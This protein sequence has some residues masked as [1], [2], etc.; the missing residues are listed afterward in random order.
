VA[1]DASGNVYV[2]D[3]VNSA[4][5]E[6]PAGCTSAAYASSACTITTLGNGFSYPGSVAVDGSGNVYVADSGNNAVKEMTAG[7]ASSSCVTTLGGG[8]ST[9]AGVAV[10]GSGNV[11]V[12]DYGTPAV[13]E[14]PPGCT[15]AAYASSA[16]TI[17]TLGGGFSSPAGV[18]VDGSGNVYV[19]GY[20]DNAVKEMPSGCASSS[21]VTPLGGGFNRPLDVAVDGSGNVY[22]ADVYN[23]AVKEIMPHGVNFG[24]VAVGGTSAPLTLYFAFNAADSGITAS[25]LTQGAKGLD[26]ADAGGGSCDTNGT[27]F[28][29]SIGDSCTVNVTFT[30]KY[31]GARDGAVELSDSSGVIATGYVYGIGTGPQIVFEPA[32]IT[33]LGGGFSPIGMAVDASGNVY[34]ADYSNSAVKEM[35]S[36]C[37]SFSCVTTLGGGFDLPR[38]VAVDGSGNVYVADTSNNRVIEMPSGCASFSCVTTLGGGFDLPYGVAVDGSGNVYVADAD[39]DAVKE[40]PPGCT[41]AAYASSACAITALGGGFSTPV[42]VAVDGS[43]N[44]YVADYANNAVKEMPAGCASFSCV[45]TPGGGFST[46]TGVAVDASGNVYVA[47]EG[48]SAVKEM[49]AGCASFSCVTALGGGFRYPQGAAVDGSG[50]VYVADYGNNAVKELNAATP[51]SFNFT[52]ATA[53]D[54]TDTA[55]GT[56]IAQVFNIGN[57]PLVFSG[58]T[59]PADF[60]EASDTNPCTS[61]TSLSAG[62]ECDVPVE[63]TPVNVGSPLSEDVTLTDNSLN[64]TSVQQS[65]PLSGTGLLAATMSSPTPSSTLTAASTQFTWNAGPAGTTGYG[66]NVGTSPGGADLVNIYPL[67]GTSTTVTLPTN[68]TTI[69]V[70]LWTVLNGTTFLYHDYTYTEFTQSG[71]AITSPS[72]GS[73]LTSASTTFTWNAGPAGT[74]GYGLNVGTTGVGSADLVNIGPLSGTSVT[75]NLPTNGTLIYVRLWTILNGTTYLSND[76]T[77]TEFTQLASAITSPTPGGTLTSAS[78]TFTWNA[79]PAGTTGYGLNVGTSGVGS[80]DL[81]NIGPLSGTSVTVNLPTN[82][83]LIYVRLWTILNG[84]TYLSNDYTYTEFTQLASAI[85]SPTPGGTLTSASTTFTWNAGPAG[86][87][88]YG[89]NVGTSPGGA[90]LVNIGPLSGTSVTVNLPTNGTLIYVR[91]WT[92]LN[93]TTYLSNDYTYTEFTQLASAITSPVPGSTLTSTSAT[94]TWNAG[95]AGTTGYGLNVGTSLG[96]AD[97]VNIGP[98]SGTSTTV[99]LPTNGTPIFVRLWTILNGT[100]YLSNDYTYT[101]FTQSASAITSPVPGS[102]LTS[103]STTFT[104][105][106]GPAGTTGYGLNVGTS[107]GGADLVNI[108]PLSGTSTTVSLPTNGTPIFVRLWTI[109]N[110]T[111]YLYNDYIYTEFTQ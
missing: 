98:L 67:S 12:A 80:A 92:I 66:L 49:P 96:G 85:T 70:R 58:L 43:G 10:D 55:D 22:V 17:T 25:A 15:S 77:Y 100:T 81:V 71:S 48:N 7:C 84:T 65:I 18:A 27:G 3:T 57:M 69:Y 105:N 24:S 110:G 91:L 56:L 29:Y 79:G 82:G 86:A 64:G 32:A 102:T 26:F 99:S 8:F 87:T 63:F 75:V 9:P 59:Y 40:M 1:V 34:V 30:P 89:L 46:P 54:S 111:T 42:G 19:A 31:A 93:G 83:T 62:Q 37:A 23:S 14:M 50:N 38:G 108:G 72:P 109:V 53:V 21:C 97:L 5:K 88:G 11:Y 4:V 60:S 33:S 90:D 107:L 2:A 41:A 76:Y 74:T 73:T 45:T 106:A 44:I 36:G 6:M 104:W 20:S 28:A 61:S 101:E 94:F 78:T 13:K 52:T 35:P 51:P 68:G 95:P 47:D 103:A 16:C 39:N